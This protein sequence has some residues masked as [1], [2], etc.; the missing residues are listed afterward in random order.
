MH[1]LTFSPSLTLYGK[2]VFIM[3]KVWV[4]SVNP[5]HE[6]ERHLWVGLPFA[7]PGHSERVLSEVSYQM[8]FND[9]L[10]SI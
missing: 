8:I 9:F 10:H 7:S 3:Q 6:D 1:P 2:V 4:A 5:G